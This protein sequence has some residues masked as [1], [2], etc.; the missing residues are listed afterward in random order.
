M[1]GEDVVRRDRMPAQGVL[2][3]PGLRQLDL[4]HDEVGDPVQQ[5]VLVRDVVVERHR[6]DPELLPEPAHAERLDPV[7]V[8]ERDGGTEHA[9][10]RQGGSSRL[11]HLDNLTVYV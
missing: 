4:A 1:G 2:P 7:V 3:I 9:L 5:V 10:S 11:R 8:G 6:L